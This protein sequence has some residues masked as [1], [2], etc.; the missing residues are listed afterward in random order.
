MTIV[1]FSRILS[2]EEFRASKVQKSLEA[3]PQECEKLAQRLGLLKLENLKAKVSV[4]R[5]SSGLIIVEG[6]LEAKIEQECV[7]TL[8]PLSTFIRAPFELRF[9]TQAKSKYMSE[10][11]D[12]SSLDAPEILEEDFLDLGEIVAQSLSL[13]IDPYLAKMDEIP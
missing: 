3:T 9:V 10:E 5:E 12:L 11:N 2:L 8:E 4:S 13:E 7:R 6:E 1:E